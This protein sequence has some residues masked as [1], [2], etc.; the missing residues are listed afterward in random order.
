MFKSILIITILPTISMAHVSK[1]PHTDHSDGSITWECNDEGLTTTPKKIFTA[2]GRICSGSTFDQNGDLVTSRRHQAEQLADQTAS[3][4][5]Y[6]FQ[7]K[8]ESEYQYRD[9]NEECLSTNPNAVRETVTA[10]Y[11]CASL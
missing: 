1:G 11:S 2:T 4:H 8:R 5:C 9:T 10:E 7:Y 6:P 3:K